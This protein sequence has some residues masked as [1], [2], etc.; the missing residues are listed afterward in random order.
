M[1]NVKK[2]RKKK[3][4][5]TILKV[6]GITFVSILC[7]GLLTVGLYVNWFLSRLNYVPAGESYTLKP[8][9]PDPDY[10]GDG[11]FDSS[12]IHYSGAPNFSWEPV[13][14]K[15][16][17]NVLLIGADKRPDQHGIG[18]SDSMIIATLDKQHKKIKLTSIMRDTY[19]FIPEGYR[20]NR[21]NAAYH[22]GG[23]QFLLNTINANFN[24]SLSKYVVVD[25]EVFKKVVDIIGGVEIEMNK[26]EVDYFKKYMRHLGSGVDKLKEGVNLLDGA[27]ALEYARLRSVGRWDFERTDRQRRLLSAIFQKG[28]KQGLGTITKIAEEALPHVTT[29][30]SENEVLSLIVDAFAMGKA[31][32][33]QLRIPYKNTFTEESRRGMSVLIPDIQANAEKI[34]DFIYYDKY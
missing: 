22:Y 3:K 29:N 1:S 34:R 16:I 31:E 4:S 27:T 15:K 9:T 25:F 24:T 26:D 28:I 6:I 30:L 5:K 10:D 17:I 14:N 2:N 33:A 32:I 13:T 11:T 18:R 20:D 12:P 23:P 19:V 8:E 7:A 21:I